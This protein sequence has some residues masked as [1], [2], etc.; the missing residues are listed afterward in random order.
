MTMIEM[1]VE[2]IGIDPQNNPLV[3]LR[4]ET[5]S[6]FVPIWIGLSEAVAIQM[7]LDQRASQRPM[8]HDLMANILREMGVKLVKVTV[9]EFEDSIYYAS[10]HLQVG[11]AADRVQELDARPSD[12]IALALR[13]H[14]G[15]FVS[16]TV[17]KKAGIQVEDAGP[18]T[19]RPKMP[20]RE[21]VTEVSPEEAE[22]LARL[23]EGVDLGDSEKN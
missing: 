19:L 8:T 10:L 4:D 13:A 14:C 6:T 11:G 5:R 3:L 2:G 23:L 18:D 22:K 15:I 16:E 20:A 21:A 12:A 17:S 7:E 9:N 1:V